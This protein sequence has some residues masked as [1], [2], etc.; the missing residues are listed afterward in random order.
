MEEYL[1]EMFEDGKKLEEKMKESGGGRFGDVKFFYLEEGKNKYRILP[2]NKKSLKYRVVKHFGKAF[3]VQLPD[4]PDKGGVWYCPMEEYGSC[5]MCE[6]YIIDR[7][8]DSGIAWKK[9]AQ[10]L[11]WLYAK[12]EDGEFGILEM[13]EKAYHK[14]Y[15]CIE[16]TLNDEDMGN[17]NLVSL[18]QGSYI[19]INQSMPKQAWEF[20]CVGARKKDVVIEG[21]MV[22]AYKDYPA[23]DKLAKVF[24]P[25]ELSMVLEND[26]SF[27]KNN[28]DSA[29][30]TETETETADEPT[31]KKSKN[32][33]KIK[34]MLD[35]DE[36]E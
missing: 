22:K 7:D 17:V 13:K 19:I 8:A 28:D 31:K 25:E 34:A 30:E 16:D 23:L 12:N 1:T 24:K 21:E 3:G 29:T 4:R 33:E 6:E 18:S 5:P 10:S 36:D 20:D 11:Y 27:I 15:K 35:D 2:Y 26:F 14:L 32:V 9:Q